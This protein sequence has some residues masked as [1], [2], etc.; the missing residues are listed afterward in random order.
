MATSTPLASQ[1][2]K[3]VVQK[4]S[5]PVATPPTPVQVEVPKQIQP[6]GTLCNG[7]YFSECPVGQNLICPQTGNAYCQSP[8]TPQ[9]VSNPSQP[10]EP[11]AATTSSDS[12]YATKKAV[13]I[14]LH[15]FWHK[16]LSVG[17]QMNTAE[18]YSVNA[19]DSSKN[20]NNSLCIAEAKSAEG[21]FDIANQMNLE[22][23][24]PSNIPMEINE[25]L[26]MYRND[27]TDIL[28]NEKSIAMAW[29]SV[30]TDKQNG[31][32]GTP[33]IN[34]LNQMSVYEQGGDKASLDRIAEITAIG[35]AN[36][37]Y[38]GADFSKLQAETETS[39]AEYGQNE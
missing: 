24:I 35:Q 17:T 36:I 33:I 1:P 28:T 27:Y 3:K 38:F 8:Q 29:E 15:D 31:M 14:S 9:S 16:N 13:L 23:T 34:T 12:E 37:K 32:F 7:T 20:S 19:G 30:C 26:F 11:S 4:V 39:Q 21:A 5:Q 25:P 2:I 10:Q 22:N 18:Q 6:T